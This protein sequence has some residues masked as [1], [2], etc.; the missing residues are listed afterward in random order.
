MVNFNSEL[1]LHEDCFGVEMGREARESEK[2][3]CASPPS[4][5]PD[6]S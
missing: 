5:M 1:F 2:D 4:P 3:D 6:G